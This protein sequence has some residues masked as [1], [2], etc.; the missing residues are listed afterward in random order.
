MDTAPA[1]VAASS[2]PI[3]RR[4]AA[5]AAALTPAALPERVRTCAK[6]HILDV[7]GTALAATRFD[8]AQ[9]A[10]SGLLTLADGGDATVI[11][12]RVRLP[13]RDAAL[14]NGILGHGLDYDDTH[15]GAIVHPSA[16]AFPCALAVAERVD[17]TGAELLAAYTLGVDV[18]TRVGV[19]AHGLM[20]AQGFHTT[21]LAGHFGCAVAAGRLYR[22]SEHQLM[23]AQ[24][25]AGST[26]SAMSEH[27]A[28]GAWNK[29]LHPGWAA[30][31]GITA[32]ALARGGFV[33]TRR[34]YEGADGLFRS[35]TGGR[36]AEVDLEAMTR[37]LGEQ[38]LIEEVAIKPYPVCHLL[39]A[40]ADAALALRTR[41]DLDPRRIA[42]V[43]ALLH[44]D[45]FHYVCEP[46]DMR[47]RPTSDYMAKFSVQYVVAACLVRGRFGFAELE[48]DAL[49]DPDILAL[50]QR[51]AHEPDP[52][53]AFPRYFSGGVRITLD[54]GRTFT[55][56]DAI[57]RGAGERALT[58]DEIIAK[59]MDNAELAVPRADAACIRDIVLD[60]ERHSAR[61]LAR[62]LALG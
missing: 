48:S 37:G 55:Q 9:H 28:D 52:D 36:L 46:A 62:V 45:V 1:A 32:A 14:L 30:V 4:I 51:V 38:W 20:H 58:A 22:L 34:I 31:G 21:G 29:R 3:S 18:A 57:N 49:N 53:S 7:V 50:A 33:G 23:V 24:G 40:C 15:P 39:H 12:M 5:A 8:F 41:H 25:L 56:H 47:R 26:T 17:A 60:L 27:R 54:D 19:A 42:H 10:L 43:Q 59:Y 2:L 61:E 35:H 6:L 16:S 44:P 13:L 11:G